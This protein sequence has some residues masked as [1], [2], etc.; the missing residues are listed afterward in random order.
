MFITL[1]SVLQ[2][3]TISSFFHAETAFLLLSRPDFPAGLINLYISFYYSIFY[4]YSLSPHVWCLS[5]L[6]VLICQHKPLVLKYTG[7]G[8]RVFINSGSLSAG[9]QDLDGFLLQKSN[10][11]RSQWTTHDDNYSHVFLRIFSELKNDT[12]RQK[13]NRLSFSVSSSFVARRDV[14]F[15]KNLLKI[16]WKAAIQPPTPGRPWW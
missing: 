10:W 4:F 14:R 8:W 6:R 1:R 12:C 5:P 15:Q 3:P 2:A 7:G 13:L 16:A 9:N 11:L